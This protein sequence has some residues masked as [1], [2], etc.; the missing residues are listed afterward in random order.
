MQAGNARL[1]N[2]LDSSTGSN[3]SAGSWATF[4]KEVMWIVASLLAC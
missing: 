4:N 1:V 2:L 3:I